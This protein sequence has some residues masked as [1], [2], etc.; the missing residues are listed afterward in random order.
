MN[1]K[2]LYY[3]VRSTS[4]PNIMNCVKHFEFKEI[5][6]VMDLLSKWLCE[7]LFYKRRTLRSALWPSCFSFIFQKFKFW[8]LGLQGSPPWIKTA[9]LTR[10]LASSPLASVIVNQNTSQRLWLF[11]LDPEGLGS[12]CSPLH[13]LF[14]HLSEALEKHKFYF[15]VERVLFSPSNLHFRIVVWAIKVSGTMIS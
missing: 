9:L 5:K 14:L 15:L 8:K 6:C 3:S 1:Y 2:L 13:A 10:I 12:A 11:V 7:Q 4:T